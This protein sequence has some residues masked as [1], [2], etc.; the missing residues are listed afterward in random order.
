MNLIPKFR[1]LIYRSLGC[2]NFS[3]GKLAY[4]IIIAAGIVFAGVSDSG[5]MEKKRAN[6]M[7]WLSLWKGL[8]YLRMSFLTTTAF[9]VSTLTK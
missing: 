5:L 6:R 7:G 8:Y 2:E 9:A 1:K 4:T 3:S